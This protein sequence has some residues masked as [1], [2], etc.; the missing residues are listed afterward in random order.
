MPGA[1]TKFCGTA[2]RATWNLRHYPQSLLGASGVVAMAASGHLFAFLPR[3][4]RKIVTY[5]LFYVHRSRK[6]WEP[7]QSDTR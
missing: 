3:Q 5:L 4:G 6:Y 1:R 7:M 2:K